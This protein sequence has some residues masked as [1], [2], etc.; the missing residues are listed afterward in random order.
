MKLPDLVL[1]EHQFEGAVMS[2]E[3]PA[4]GLPAAM[5]LPPKEPGA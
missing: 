4:P 1:P 3:A 5:M 2:L